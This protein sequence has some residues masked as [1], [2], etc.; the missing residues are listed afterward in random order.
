MFAS[1]HGVKCKARSKSSSQNFK[2]TSKHETDSEKKL[3]CFISRV[4]LRQ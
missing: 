4:L 1:K 3:L 2:E